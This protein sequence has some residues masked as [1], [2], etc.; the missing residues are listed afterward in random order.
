MASSLGPRGSLELLTAGGTP[1][2]RMEVAP[3]PVAQS[4]SQHRMHIASR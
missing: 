1:P 4:L 3:L 2:L